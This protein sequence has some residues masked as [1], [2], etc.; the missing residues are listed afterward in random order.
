MARAHGSPSSLRLLQ[1][2]LLWTPLYRGTWTLGSEREEVLPG[3]L[4]HLQR[5]GRSEPWLYRRS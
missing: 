4:T 5:T 2:H 1:A 3:L